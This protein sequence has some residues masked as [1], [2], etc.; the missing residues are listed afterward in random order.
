MCKS[1]VHLKTSA[2]TQETRA[3]LRILELGQQEVES[4]KVAPV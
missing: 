3:L 1:I 4:G 2:I